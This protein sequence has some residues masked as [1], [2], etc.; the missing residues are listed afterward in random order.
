ML[1]D[2]F[3]RNREPT[4]LNKRGTMSSESA[5]NEVRMLN[6]KEAARS[7]GISYSTMKRWIY[8]QKI[9]SVKTVGG[10]YRI[11]ETELDTFLHRASAAQAGR[12]PGVKPPP[13]A[14]GRNQLV[15]RVVDVKIVGLMAQVTVSIGEQSITAVISADSVREMDLQKGSTVGALIM[16]TSVM[17]LRV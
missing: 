5:E 7:L 9:H 6:P 4:G 8:T 16:S 2:R 1:H 10:H 11:S 14:S 13:G 17:I 3:R 12:E 15:G